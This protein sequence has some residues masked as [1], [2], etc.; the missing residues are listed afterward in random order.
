ME[1]GGSYLGKKRS[2]PLK[3]EE[4]RNYSGP[5]KPRHCREEKGKHK[6]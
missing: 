4:P 6:G 3:F 1:F 5:G 2:K